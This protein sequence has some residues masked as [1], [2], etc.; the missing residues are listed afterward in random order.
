MK[1]LTPKARRP[2]R[3]GSV[4]GIDMQRYEAP[5]PAGASRCA[6]TIAICTRDNVSAAT[7]ISL[8]MMQRDKSLTLQPGEF[9]KTYIVVGNVLTYQR[10]QCVRDFEGDWLLFIDA[11]MTWQAQDVQTLIETREKWDLDM[12]GG[13]CFQRSEPY[14]PTL[15]MRSPDDPD[16]YTFLETWPEDSA[17]EVDATGMA[18]CLIHKRVFD[19]ITQQQGGFE[20]P[21]F[22]ERQQYNPIAFYRWEDRWGEDFRFCREAKASGSRIFVDTSVKPGHVGA[23][24]ITERSFWTSI[25]HRDP[26]SQ[27]FREKVL[28]SIDQ[29]ALTRDE[30]IKRLEP[31]HDADT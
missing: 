11:D 24:L 8:M 3:A 12:V 13:L 29:Q 5:A 23:Q 10:N 16:A 21:D 7:A 26:M 31:W 30:A 6:G 2:K 28:E 22:E 1:P 17:L 14:Q 25:A 18:F 27:E 9:I 19:R 4:D 15:Y 20:F